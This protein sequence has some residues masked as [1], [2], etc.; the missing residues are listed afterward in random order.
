[1]RGAFVTGTDTGVG[2]TVVAS[3]I[4]AALRARGLRVAAVK[5]V[6]T[7]LDDPDPGRPADHELLAAA[8]GVAP[9]S[10]TTRTFGPPL[11]P[12][13]AAE[14]ADA[15]LN[16][17]ELLTAARES[18]AGADVVIAEGAGGLMVPLVAGDEPYLIRDYALDLGLP[19]IIAAR[20][21]L[22]T[23]N[24]TLL[25]IE[26]GRA[27]GLRVLGVVL[28]PWPDERSVMQLS[29]RTTIASLGG[30]AVDVLPQVGLAP[31]AL[32]AAGAT[33]MVTELLTPAPA[34]T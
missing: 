26:A 34:T 18:A 17:D 32:A 19:L 29:N 8:A 28:T 20:P 11:S 14:L 5:P 33:L 10:V 4:A 1:M 21:G 13:L 15:P 25:T 2:K 3:C 16:P 9:S 22:G 30:V 27:H 12:H 24:H 7:G 6:V 23:I 31:D